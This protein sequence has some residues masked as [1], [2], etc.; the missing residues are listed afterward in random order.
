MAET[1]DELYSEMAGCQACRLRQCCTQV[2]LAVGQRKN[3]ALMVI[4]EAPGKSEDELGEP[5]VGKAGELVKTVLRNTGILNR[6]NTIITH[7]LKCKPPG[8]KFPKDD[9]PEICVSKWLWEE[10]RLAQPKR[11]L[12]FGAVPLKYV[13]GLEGITTLRGQWHMVRGIRTMATFHPSFILRK[14]GEGYTMFRD[15]FVKDINEVAQ[16]IKK[17]LEEGKTVEKEKDTQEVL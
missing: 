4:G 15:N 11:L 9:C 14:D 5:F 6:Q 2:V 8:E 3:P 16:E 17:I 7:T 12:L 10:I 13:S 1:L